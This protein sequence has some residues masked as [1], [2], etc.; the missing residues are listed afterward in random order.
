MCLQ[1]RHVTLGKG[2]GPINTDFLHTYY[3]PGTA[4]RL[5]V[6]ASSNDKSGVCNEGLSLLNLPHVATSTVSR[7]MSFIQIHWEQGW[8][9]GCLAR[10]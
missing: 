4:R 5:H 7:T 9:P 8:R 2:L 6:V 3:V 1:H 10:G